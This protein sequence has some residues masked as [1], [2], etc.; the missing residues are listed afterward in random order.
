MES[1]G[2]ILTPHETLLMVFSNSLKFP[3]PTRSLLK[4]DATF[5][6]LLVLPEL[7]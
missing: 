7:S 6:D 2:T 4:S 1:L 3:E 5:Y